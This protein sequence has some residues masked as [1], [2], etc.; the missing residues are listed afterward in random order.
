MLRRSERDQHHGYTFM[1]LP[2]P[3]KKAR[4]IHVSRRTARALAAAWAGAMLLAAWL[5]YAS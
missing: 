2:G 1:L 5:G 3:G 4:R